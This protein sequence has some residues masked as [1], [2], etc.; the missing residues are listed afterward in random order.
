VTEDK[1]DFLA[2]LDYIADLEFDDA[3][4]FMKK[5]GNVL[6]QHAPALTTQFLK[7]KARSVDATCVNICRFCVQSSFLTREY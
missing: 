1:K 5:Y 4:V 2:A 3:D 6:I 7:R